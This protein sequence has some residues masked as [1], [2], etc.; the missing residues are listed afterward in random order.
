MSLENKVDEDKSSV[1]VVTDQPPVRSRF[2]WLLIPTATLAI[3]GCFFFGA[4]LLSLLILAHIAVTGQPLYEPGPTR[5]DSRGVAIVI[6]CIPTGLILFLSAQQLWRRHWIRTSLLIATCIGT[7]VAMDAVIHS[8]SNVLPAYPPDA[9]KA[10][11]ESILKVVIFELP[12]TDLTVQLPHEP[13]NDYRTLDTELGKIEIQMYQAELAYPNTEAFL[14]YSAVVNEYPVGFMNTIASTHDGDFLQAMADEG[15]LKRPGSNVLERK[16]ITL[17]DLSG[18]EERIVIPGGRTGKLDPDMP[19]IVCRRYYQKNNYVYLFQ[20]MTFKSAHD[21]SP[22]EFDQFAK[23]FFD[24][25][26]KSDSL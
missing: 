25:I 19:M 14:F 9:T 1:G 23:R 7:C 5:I 24:S 22:G 2:R 16:R 26:R 11:D 3:V 10:P 21:S 8:L 20:L 15:V 4:G 17:S 13:T 18:I 12:G 6:V